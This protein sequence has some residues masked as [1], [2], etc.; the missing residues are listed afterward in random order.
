MLEQRTTLYLSTR[1]YKEYQR[2]RK[3]NNFNLSRSINTIL[4]V[5]WFGDTPNDLEF[6][7]DETKKKLDKI[8]EQ[9]T[10]LE[11]RASDIQKLL[12]TKEERNNNELT[13]FKHFQL[14]VNNRI[15]NMEKTG[16][17][18]DYEKLS[19]IWHRDFFPNN[20]LTIGI[21]KDIF[22]RFKNKSFD[23]D[24]FQQLR[25]GDVTGN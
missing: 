1:N 22:Y 9:R 16:Y 7:L 23:F 18:T 14:N 2:R 12:D 19:G 6:E 5:Q 13:L 3:E 10:I 21:V 4:E 15:E 17:A 24:F 8:N 11:L 25:R 20:H